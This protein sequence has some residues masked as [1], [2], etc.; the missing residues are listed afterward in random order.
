MS[1]WIR[2]A[3]TH[4]GCIDPSIW[5]ASISRLKYGFRV[6]N[7]Q[8]KSSWEQENLPPMSCLMMINPS[9]YTRSRAARGSKKGWRKT[10]PVQITHC[11]LAEPSAG[12]RIS[13]LCQ[14][15]PVNPPWSGT[16]C[17]GRKKHKSITILRKYICPVV[18][19]WVW[20]T[21]AIFVSKQTFYVRK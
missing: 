5:S 20:A 1:N 16:K 19:L 12:L 3:C 15:H 18:I 2:E 21:S 7:L 4:T 14:R 8:L 11:R 9:R 6:S 17:D 13:Q 10:K